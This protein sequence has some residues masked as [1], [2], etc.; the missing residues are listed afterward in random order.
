MLSAP[1]GH[2]QPDTNH[3]RRNQMSKYNAIISENGNGFPL[4]DALICDRNG[5]GAIHR[6]V[7]TG[8]IC[9][10]NAGAANYVYAE[11][12]TTDLDW[13]DVSDDELSDCGLE[14]LGEGVEV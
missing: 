10:G 4:D 7:S 5:N 11:L 14:I 6:I 3:H 13:D 9:T 1:A 8:R 2:H 12:V